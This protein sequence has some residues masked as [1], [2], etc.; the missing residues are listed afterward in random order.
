MKRRKI[1]TEEVIHNFEQL[2]LEMK[3]DKKYFKDL[4]KKETN[5]LKKCILCKRYLNSQ[6][7]SPIL[8]SY[9]KTKFNI[10]KPL[11]AISG[12]GIS[13]KQKN[14]EIK[15]SLGSSD[16]QLNFVQLRPH[17]VIDYYLFLCYNLYEETIGKI[18]WF[19]VPSKEL[20]EL[21]PEYG[22]YA[23]N[24]LEE[25]GKITINNIYGDNKYE[26][27]LRTNPTKENKQKSKRLWNI[28]IE[29]YNTSEE[30]IIKMIFL[31]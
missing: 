15:V 23:H 1:I 27:A 26:Y 31:N 19:L 11:N 2:V 9:I 22:G 12:D 3:N 4:C 13:P 6:A 30:D 28:L 14:I 16:G 24:S 10:T 7:S 8:E 5:I 18:Y 20:Y 29:K 21:L 17:H 25:N